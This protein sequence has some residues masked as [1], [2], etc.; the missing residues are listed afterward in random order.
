VLMFSE[1][2]LKCFSSLYMFLLGC[3][4]PNLF[5]FFKIYSYYLLNF[6][7]NQ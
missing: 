2:N 5:L 7:E 4:S 3:P 1:D 6:K